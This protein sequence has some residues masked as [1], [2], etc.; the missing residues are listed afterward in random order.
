M[1]YLSKNIAFPGIK[2]SYWLL[3]PMA[4]RND[5]TMHFCC[6]TGVPFEGTERRGGGGRLCSW[7]W[8]ASKQWSISEGPQMPG[9]VP[10]TLACDKSLHLRELGFENVRD[11]WRSKEYRWRAGGQTSRWTANQW[12]VIPAA[13]L[14]SVAVD[15][16]HQL[17][18]GWGVKVRMKK[19]IS[20]CLR[21]SLPIWAWLVNG[22]A[23]AS[24]CA[25]VTVI[26]Q[27]SCSK[28]S[29]APSF[30]VFYSLDS[31][32]VFFQF[33]NLVFSQSSVLRV[34][35]PTFRC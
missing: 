21:K 14:D 6:L 30:C 9:S 27:I 31:I 12:L 20:L 33:L 19:N 29:L 7:K 26:G 28:T 15:P 24:W 5:I 10:Q 23:G 13:S 22:R 32:F 3:K 2:P 17:L 1:A 34:V 16:I 8:K 35:L 4:I 25:K 11:G 18:G